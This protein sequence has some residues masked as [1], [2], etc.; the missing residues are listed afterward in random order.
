[1]A[2]YEILCA[3]AS[4]V[5]LEVLAEA[6]P[7]DRLVSWQ[8]ACPEKFCLA[9]LLPLAASTDFDAPKSCFAPAGHR[10]RQLFGALRL[11][12]NQK[13]KPSGIH[14]SEAGGSRV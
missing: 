11:S 2:C 13:Q 14:W 1:M 5:S 10:N 3:A 6:A 12:L 9:E 8:A 7:Y 4:P